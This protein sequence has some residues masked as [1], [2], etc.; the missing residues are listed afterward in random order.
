MKSNKVEIMVEEHGHH[1]SFLIA[2]IFVRVGVTVG[3]CA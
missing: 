1:P 2:I 3:K